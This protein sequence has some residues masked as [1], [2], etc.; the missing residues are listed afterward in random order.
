MYGSA[1][2]PYVVKH[3][4]AYLVSKSG[5]TMR[6]LTDGVAL[7]PTTEKWFNGIVRTPRYETMLAYI[8]LC[9]EKGVRFTQTGYRV[10]RS[11]VHF[12]C[13]NDRGEALIDLPDFKLVTSTDATA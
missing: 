10:T 1:P 9:E 12:L 5:Q 8:R 7:Y 4:L 13:A 3:A 6:A 2:H 11:N